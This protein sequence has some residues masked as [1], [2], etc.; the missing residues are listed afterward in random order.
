MSMTGDF[1]LAMGE[2]MKLTTLCYIEKDG[3]Y[4][5]LHRTKKEHDI[6][7]GKYIGV[8]G[9]FE[10]GES[11]DECI[12]RE[13]KEETGLKL[14]KYRARGIVTFVYG[15]D[16]VEYMHLYTADKFT[17]KLTDCDEG[18]L[19]W[20]PVDEVTDL[21]LWDGD[22]IFLK[23]LQ[24]DA[25]FFSLKLVYNL[26][27]ELI[28]AIL[29]GKDVLKKYKTVKRT[30]KSKESTSSEKKKTAVKKDILKDKDIREPLFNFLE[31]TYGKVRI[32]EEK[33]VGRSRADILMV[34]TDS[35]YG[36]EIKSDADNYTR[37]ADQVKDYDKYFDYNIVVVGSTH[38]EHTHE[39][40]PPYWGI[41]TVEMVDG[42]FDFYFLR[43]PQLNPKMK[44]KKKSRQ[45]Y[46]KK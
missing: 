42:A 12:I 10:H 14:S 13:V 24:Q 37:L 6:N 16:T 39:H 17:G 45:P 26:N 5:M 15:E 11:P 44:W 43:K 19:V 21:N 36:I 34:A 30:L 18:E 33:T 46:R 29:D 32:L 28:S 31:D 22:R 20:V 35:L 9:H 25:P 4:L 38:G 40:V 23:L 2:N 41:I 7:K 1:I 8:G 3:K 27:D